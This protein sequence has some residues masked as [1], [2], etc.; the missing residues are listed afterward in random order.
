SRRP[1]WNN[2]GDSALDLALDQACKRRLIEAI[3]FEWR[4][5]CRESPFEHRACGSM[6]ARTQGQ[7][8]RTP[9]CFLPAASSDRDLAVEHEIGR[10]R[11]RDVMNAPAIVIKTYGENVTSADPD[12]H[13]RSRTAQLT[14]DERTRHHAC[15]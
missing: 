9:A 13:W 15:P 6:R 5:E 14:K 3:V 7:A 1:Y 10:S 11:Q 12:P 8:I 4:N 2:A